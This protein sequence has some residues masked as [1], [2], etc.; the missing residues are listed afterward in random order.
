LGDL[1]VLGKT[2][3][4]LTQLLQVEYGK[5]LQNP[6]FTVELKDFEKPYFIASG[7]VTHPGKYELRG[8]TTVAQAVAIAGG[9][10]EQAK[11]SQVL[12]FR[13]VSDDWA[14]VIQL[15]VKKM[16]QEA[17]L[18]EDLHLQPGDMLF[19]PKNLLSKIER[20]I[21]TSRLSL[22]YRPF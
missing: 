21:P 22:S 10:N 8:D 13:R 15:N 19:V 4:E 3:P 18:R 5:I 6:D 17:S 12:L 2:I 14:E 7:E 20:F 16:L 11:H 1:H 9:F